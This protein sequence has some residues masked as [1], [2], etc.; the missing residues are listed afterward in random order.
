MEFPAIL[1]DLQDFGYTMQDFG[2][3]F[4]LLHITFV[5]KENTIYSP[6]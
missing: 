4:S 6:F 1:Q 5:R 2:Y 3:T